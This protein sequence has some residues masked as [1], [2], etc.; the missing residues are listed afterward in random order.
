VLETAVETTREVAQ[1][2]AAPAPVSV[3]PVAQAELVTPVTAP[4]VAAPAPA[5]VA[6]PVAT[7]SV[8]TLQPMLASAGLT[9]V[10][11]DA[12]KLKAAQENAARH[13]EAPR[14][15]RVRKALPPVDAAPMQQVETDASN[16]A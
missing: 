3:A 11:T 16:K 6:T 1:P 10:N 15:P 8:E 12:A 7:V 2:V 4:A 13:A 14:A 9:W 5:V